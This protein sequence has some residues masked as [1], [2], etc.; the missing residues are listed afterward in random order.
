M[1]IEDLRSLFGRRNK[2]SLIDVI[3]MTNVVKSHFVLE[4][5]FNKHS[6]TQH[7]SFTS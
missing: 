2:L 5:L 7:A 3:N 1:V 6:L 4:F